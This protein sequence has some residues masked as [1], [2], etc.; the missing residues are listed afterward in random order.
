M[1]ARGRFR[2]TFH[3]CARACKDLPVSR[4]SLPAFA[5]KTLKAEDE[6]PATPSLVSFLQEHLLKKLCLVSQPGKISGSWPAQSNANLPDS[7]NPS[8]EALFQEIVSLRVVLPSADF[9]QNEDLAELGSQQPHGLCIATCQSV[10]GLL[11][12]DPETLQSFPLRGHSGDAGLPLSHHAH[13]PSRV[14]RHGQGVCSQLQLWLHPTK[15]TA[16]SAQRNALAPGCP[17]QLPTVLLNLLGAL[18]SKL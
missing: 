5:P 17:S 18:K 15:G 14:S 11:Q 6:I 2:R 13:T 12:F 9:E 16:L 4:H 8:Q 10:I 1:T 7:A 3:C